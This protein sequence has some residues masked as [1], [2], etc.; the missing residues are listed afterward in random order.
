MFPEWQNHKIQLKSYIEMKMDDSSLVEDILQEV[1]IKANENLQQ[2]KVQGSLKS[3]LYRITHNV[4]M[5]YY[6]QHKSYDELPD[7]IEQE[8]RDPIEE[9]HQ[10][11]ASCIKPLIQELPDKYRIPLELAELEGMSQKDIAIKLGLSLSGAKSRIQ[12]GRIKLREIML[13]CCDFEISKGG[14]TD[15]APKNK[16]GQKYYDS[17]RNRFT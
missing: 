17:M 8:E 6:R 11:L 9:N 12:R 4:I 16:L 5:D 14:V 3:W 2:L 15:F 10:A 1:Y 13:A 7:S